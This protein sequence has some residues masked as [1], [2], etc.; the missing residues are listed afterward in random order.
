[1]SN[2]EFP[3]S[4][5]VPELG[6]GCNHGKM[7]MKTSY[8]VTN[9]NNAQTLLWNKYQTLAWI[10]IEVAPGQKRLWRGGEGA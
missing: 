7:S 4:K 1:M 9:N 10:L 8:L 2:K 6:I 5:W 3:M